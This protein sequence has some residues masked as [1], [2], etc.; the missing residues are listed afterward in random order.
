[1]LLRF[2]EPDMLN[3]QLDDVHTGEFKYNIL[4]KASYIH[5]IN[6]NAVDVASRITTISD[7]NNVVATIEWTGREKRTGGIIKIMGEEPVKFSELFDGCESVTSIQ[8]K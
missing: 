3:T 8:E 2:S 1:M 4:S 5:G 6:K 7:A